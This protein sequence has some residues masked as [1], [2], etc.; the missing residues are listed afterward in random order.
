MKDNFIF[1][2]SFVDGFQFIDDALQEI[3]EEILWTPNELIAWLQPNQN[4]HSQNALECY[5]TNS[6]EGEEDPHK[7]NISESKGQREVAR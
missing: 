6:K 3:R 2:F 1:T 4:A 7:N 5:N